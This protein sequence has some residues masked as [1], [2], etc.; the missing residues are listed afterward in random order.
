[1]F[2]IATPQTVML[3]IPG[4]DSPSTLINFRSND[5]DTSRC[6]LEIVTPEGDT[7]RLTF[8]VRGQMVDS[9]FIDHDSAPEEP[10]ALAPASYM[11][12]G[13][14][15]RAFNPYTYQPPV[16]A[17]AASRPPSG[18]K[19]VNVPEDQTKEHHELR[20]KDEREAAK[21]G[22]E[23]LGK[24]LGKSG[25]DSKDKA[26]REKRA[27]H[28]QMENDYPGST[29]GLDTGDS[30]AGDRNASVQ[31]FPNDETQRLVGGK[32]MDGSPQHN[33]DNAPM[34]PAPSSPL[35]GSPPPHPLNQPDPGKINTSK[36]LQGA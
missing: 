1:M 14:D 25:E 19:A 24:H 31:T 2:A 21:R 12:N 16:S 23:M 27:L 18:F 8:N 20:E 15:T 29:L 28:D 3:T 33:P 9:Q 35:P 30:P 11:V 36:D 6:V 7:H 13:V 34:A 17:D 4:D 5:A 22:K 32:R 26:Y 10:E